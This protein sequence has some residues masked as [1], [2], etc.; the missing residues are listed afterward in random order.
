MQQS[1]ITWF[2][3]PASNLDRAADFY[4]KVVDAQL[5]RETMGSIAMAVFPYDRT[6]GIGGAVVQASARQ[7]G[8]TGSIVYLHVGKDIDAA[9]QRIER[10]GGR[11][12][13][14]KTQL[15]SDGGYYAHIIDSEGNRVGVHAN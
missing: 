13:H 10:A 4:A 9:L 1:A 8:P 2:E 11:I 12:V 3:I 5:I 6:K 14:Q 15:P 7:P